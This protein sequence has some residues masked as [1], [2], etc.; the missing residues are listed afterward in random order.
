MCSTRRLLHAL[1]ERKMIMIVNV[2]S[3]QILELLES[4]GRSFVTVPSLRF[5]LITDWP[6]LTVLNTIQVGLVASFKRRDLHHRVPPELAIVSFRLF[7]T[8]E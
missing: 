7:A 3:R 8:W 5:A 4:E 6:V 1:E 2:G